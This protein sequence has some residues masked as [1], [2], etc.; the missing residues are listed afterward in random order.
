MSNSASQIA[1]CL[2]T[3]ERLET[4]KRAAE[5]QL[6]REQS[7]QRDALLA[8]FDRLERLIAKNEN[9]ISQYAA[10]CEIPF[11]IPEVRKIDLT[12]TF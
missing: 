6:E 7:E 10:K 5:S 1:R 4:K 12:V 2:E 3:V 9:S 8:R 11:V